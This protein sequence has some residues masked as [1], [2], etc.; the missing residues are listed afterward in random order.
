MSTR[1][2]ARSIQLFRQNIV[3]YH[4]AP[5]HNAMDGISPPLQ[6][7]KIVDLTR[8]LAGPTATMLLA[9]LGADVIK[10]EE[11]AR[12]DDTSN[13]F[14]NCAILLRSSLSQGHGVR[15]LLRSARMCQHPTSHPSQHTSLPLTETRDPSLSTL[16]HP[17]DFRFSTN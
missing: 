8:I 10:V 13:C 6:G 1:L 16:K 2:F 12:G 9:D 5:F 3:R 11:V 14:T 7:I 4:K 17:K 15:L